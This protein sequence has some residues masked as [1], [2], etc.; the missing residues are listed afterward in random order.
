[1][2]NVTENSRNISHVYLEFS[3]QYLSLNVAA[4]EKELDKH[5]A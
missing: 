1:M 2:Q 4:V 5:F 3:P